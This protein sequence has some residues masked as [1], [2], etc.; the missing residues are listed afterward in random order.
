MIGRTL[1]HYKI[2]DLLGKGGM[3]VVYR[4]QDTIL[5]RHVALKV[6]PSEMTDNQQRLQRFRREAETLA[7]LDHPGIVTVFSVEQDQG[8]HFLTM[9]LVEGKRLS[10]AIS[11]GALPLE[12]IFQISVPLA[13]AIT[14]AHEKGIVHRDLKPGNIMITPE[15][16]VKVLDFGLAKLRPDSDEASI[17]ELSTEPLTREGRVLGTM[18]YMSPEQLQGGLVDARSDIFS[19]GIVLH[20]IATGERPFQGES[21]ASLITSICRDKPPSVDVLRQDLPHQLGRII[22][23]CLEK[24]VE[25][26]FQTAKDVRNELE[27]LGREVTL[28]REPAALREAVATPRRASSKIWTGVLV[29][30]AVA[31]GLYWGVARMSS[32]PTASERITSIAVLPLHNLSGDSEQEYFADGMTEAL[33]TDLAKI[34]SLKVISR[35]S[36]LRYKGVARPLKEIGRELGVDALVEG[37]VLQADNRIRITAQLIHAATDEH[38]WAESYDRD[39]H[40]ILA[41]QSEVARAIAAEIEAVMTPDER[42]R[43]TETRT[44]APAAYEAYLKGRFHWNKRTWQS[45]VS[46][47]DY[48]LETI[49]LEPDWAPAYAGLADTYALIGSYGFMAPMATYP[50]AKAAARRALE[51]DAANA[52][53]R[54]SLGW[55]HLNYDWDWSAAERELARAIELNPSYATA[56]HWYALYS[57][58]MRRDQQAVAE[59]GRALELDPLSLII[60]TNSGWIDYFARRWDQAV[61]QYTEVLALDADFPPAMWKKAQ[62]L[63]ALG[64]YDEA[65]AISLQGTERFGWNPHQ[66]GQLLAKAGRE[67]EA[68]SLVDKLLQTAR[69]EYVSP[70]E[71]AAVYVALDD[72]DQA[73]EWLERGFE[74]RDGAMIFLGVE[75]RFDSLRQDERFQAL[76][77]RLRLQSPHLNAGNT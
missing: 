3:G 37:S 68:R 51:I 29:A 8:V 43:L 39:L 72:H 20:E 66:L 34:S 65:I 50:Q 26:R 33:I 42:S 67:V 4:A 32:G 69:S 74:E 18:P 27:D 49:E 54:A 77:A 76:L 56:R 23:R 16:R 15:G 12:Q 22:G 31:L 40:D 41:L 44:I 71:I 59:I 48:F 35:T 24:D 75:P 61:E 73:I 57:A 17:T 38:L 53:A 47:R 64:R 60:A 63:G 62:V 10:T 55:V 2:L 21:S 70:S 1:G 46:A 5:R 9:Q 45:L 19:L 58:A 36:V 13:D 25:H 11:R 30:L 28:D 52:E 14:A 6:L 7:A